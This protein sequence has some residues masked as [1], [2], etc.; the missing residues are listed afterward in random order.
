MSPS[1]ST[2]SPASTRQSSAATRAWQPP[3]S[4]PSTPTPTTPAPTT[5]PSTSSTLP[6][7]QRSLH[8]HRCR[9]PRRQLHRRFPLDSDLC[10]ITAVAAPTVNFIDASRWTAISASSP[11]SQPPTSTSST[12][13][14]SFWFVVPEERRVAIDSFHTEFLG[15]RHCE[16]KSGRKATPLPSKSAPAVEAD[17]TGSCT[18]AITPPAARDAARHPHRRLLPLGSVIYIITAVAATSTSA[19]TPSPTIDEIV[20]TEQQHLLRQQPSSGGSLL[21]P[22]STS[23]SP[24]RTVSRCHPHLAA[25]SVN[26]I[27]ADANHTGANRSTVN[28][29]DDAG[30]WA[31]I[32]TSP[33]LPQQHKH[34]D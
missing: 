5:P 31:A 20:R 9:S 14:T 21:L 32:A 6:A 30:R 34:E 1:T 16:L 22:T 13:P 23:T 27:D 33:P 19:S 4:T 28:Q 26:I 18:S 7:G 10:I 2:S 12:L 17:Y 15:F 25:P 24:S 3:A 11:L 8:H 29:I